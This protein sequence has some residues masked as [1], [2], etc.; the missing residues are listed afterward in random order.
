MLITSTTS[1]HECGQGPRFDITADIVKETNRTTRPWHTVVEV[2][3]GE[4]FLAFNILL[5]V[6]DK[7]DG[8][9]NRYV[10]L[11]FCVPAMVLVSREHYPYVIF[12]GE[13][14]H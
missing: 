13:V 6:M 4:G 14:L 5:P 12:F 7:K 9:M 2:F 10:L 8:T 11:T 1:S 3:P